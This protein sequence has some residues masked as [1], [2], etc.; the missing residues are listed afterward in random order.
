MGRK[1]AGF[2]SYL[3]CVWNEIFATSPG[4][5]MEPVR[6]KR[7]KLRRYLGSF[8]RRLRL[9]SFLAGALREKFTCVRQ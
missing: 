4:T 5:I 7:R 9:V 2:Y 6:T 3:D 8:R 1:L